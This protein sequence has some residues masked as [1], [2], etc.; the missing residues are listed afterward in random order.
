MKFKSFYDFNLAW[1]DPYE[2]LFWNDLNPCISVEET[3]D[4][5]VAKYYLTLPL[6]FSVIENKIIYR[7]KILSSLNLTNN[8][9]IEENYEYQYDEIV[10]KN[11]RTKI[12]EYLNKN[13]KLDIPYS[14]IEMM[15]IDKASFFL[16]NKSL[17]SHE[18]YYWDNIKEIDD[19]S[20]ILYVSDAIELISNKV[21]DKKIKQAILDNYT[22]Q[23]GLN[24]R[25]NFKLI[26]FL[27]RHVKDPNI[28]TQLISLN[29][30]D[31]II[32]FG[33]DV[34]IFCDFLDFLLKHG[35][36][37]NDLLKII[38]ECDDYT[39]IEKILM[40]FFNIKKYKY[41][42]YFIDNSVSLESI[43]DEFN[44]IFKRGI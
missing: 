39:I 25:F 8:G 13:R 38:I 22:V 28:L 42:E 4:R 15:T 10:F 26:D 23:I 7:E 1:S 35:Y 32:S 43:R 14:S 40:L 18:F 24:K 6:N 17:K 5:L 2:F 36:T 9:D 33:H 3:E 34:S 29:L 11:L 31:T 27:T 30:E 37:E 21:K 16:K 12:D 41:E 44:K 20:K 19:S